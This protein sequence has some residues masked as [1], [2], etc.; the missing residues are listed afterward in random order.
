MEGE[1][2]ETIGIWYEKSTE[3]KFA[4]KANVVRRQTG[5]SRNILEKN[6]KRNTHFRNAEI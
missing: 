1:K 4:K 5:E 2:Q 3:E 6:Q